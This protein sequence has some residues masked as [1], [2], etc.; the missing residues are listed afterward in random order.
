MKED[1]I[2]M[3]ITIIQYKWEHTYTFIVEGSR[4]NG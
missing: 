1:Y 2:G 4:Y 3:F